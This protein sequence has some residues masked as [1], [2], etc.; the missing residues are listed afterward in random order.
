[1]EGVPAELLKVWGVSK[2][3]TVTSTYDHRV[4]QGAE[5]GAFLRDIAGLLGGAEGFYDEIRAALGLPAAAPLVFEASAEA[6]AAAPAIEASA[7]EETLRALAGAMSLLRS[8]RTYG[9]LAAHLDPLGSPPPGDPSLDPAWV[10]LTPDMM[11]RVPASLLGVA[12]PGAT[13]AEAYPALKDTYCGTIAYEIEHI[14]DH[15]QRQWL[16]EFIESGQVRTP[17]PRDE[18]RAMLERL[19]SVEVFERFLRPCCL[20]PR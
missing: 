9:H 4:I 15:D 19:V 6:P 11:H 14:S 2:V 13:F 7:D 17:L 1:M 8:F 12:V 3:M 20:W 16:R 18:R 5:S 10:G